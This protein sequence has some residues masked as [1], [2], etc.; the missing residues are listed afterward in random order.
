M[1]TWALWFGLIL[2]G[3]PATVFCVQVFT[4]WYRSDFEPSNTDESVDFD[5]LPVTVILVP[6]HNEEK[7]ISET[8]IQLKG[9]TSKVS[10]LVVA[11]NCT[12]QTAQIAR[13]L[14]ARVVERTS[15]T[16]RG[17]G[18]A[19]Q[20]GLDALKDSAP[21]VVIVLDA[22][23]STTTTDMHRLAWACIR[24]CAPVQGI[25]LMHAPLGAPM[26]SKVAEFAWLVKTM[27]RPLGW[28]AWGGAS[29]LMGSGFA[30]PWHIASTL[31]LASGHIVEDMKLSVDLAARRQ[32]PQFVTDSKV[33]STF[34]AVDAAQTTQR[35]RWEHG[36]LSMVLTEVPRA[37]VNAIVSLN[38]QLL[39]VALDLMV[40]PLSLLVLTLGC[41]ASLAVF[42]TIVW[43][44]SLPGVLLVG[45]TVAL[46]AA[47]LLAWLTWGRGVLSVREMLLI[48]GFIWR[49][50]GVYAGFVTK[51]ERNWTRTDRD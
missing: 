13:D 21:E 19:L 43:E 14:G 18:Y 22:D 7:V 1:M 31:N 51:R 8:L 34:P 2:C 17:K 41:F 28:R 33:E 35:R 23:C 11:D 37:I 15:A 27:V 26:G 40:P 12:D 10:L 9:L 50:L 6:A 25:Y 3:A 5:A 42:Q 39:S 16:L 46:V 24:R 47:V 30:L 49:K 36:H 32:A 48:P 44:A 29:Q 45:I 4:A 38:G 20:H